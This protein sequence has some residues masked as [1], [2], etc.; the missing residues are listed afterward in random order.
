MQDKE[1][2]NI[3]KLTPAECAVVISIDIL[4][5]AGKPTTPKEI[6]DFLKED[7]QTVR[8]ILE[9]LR[10]KDIV[11]SSLGFGLAGLARLSSSS[12]VS[13]RERIHRLTSNIESIL[14]QHPEILDWAKVGL[15][16]NDKSELMEYINE[17]AEEQ[18]LA[19]Y[20]LTPLHKAAQIGDVEIVKLLLERGADPNA[21]DNDGHTPLHVAAQEGHVEIVKILLERGADPRIADNGGHIPLDYAKGSAIRSLLES[22]L[23]NS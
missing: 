15:S 21:K 5:K 4:S 20:G 8:N 1:S 19:S 17:R 7:I 18:R 3:K 6:A 13:G 2:P 10:K 11:I 9:R 12:Q 22:A 14:Q 23:R 16:I